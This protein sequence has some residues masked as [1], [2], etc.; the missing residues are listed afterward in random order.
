MEERLD[1]Y[2]RENCWEKEIIRL[3]KAQISNKNRELIKKYINEL[4]AKGIGN[5]RATKLSA[6]LRRIAV[7]LDKDFNKVTRGDLLGFLV[8]LNKDNL[9]CRKIKT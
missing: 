2:K 9:C 5:N 1:I 6:Q 4:F 3:N 7:L 8:K